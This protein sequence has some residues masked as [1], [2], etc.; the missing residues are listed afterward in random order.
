[1]S[2][3]IGSWLRG[4]A[5]AL[6][7]VAIL[8][9]LIL[10]AVRTG[11]RYELEWIEGS[12]LNEVHRILQGNQLYVAPS[13]EFVP[14]LYPPLYYY[15]SAAV[16]WVIG[17]QMPALRLVSL[18]ATLGTLGLIFSMVRFETRSI[19]AGLV[20]A[21]LYAAMFHLS[22][23]WFDI[24]RVDS[25]F[26]LLLLAA[27]TI[28][29]R[30]NSWVL[31]AAAGL[32]MALAFLTKQSA[33]VVAPALVIPLWLRRP[34]WAAVYAV[35]FLVVAGGSILL[36][37]RVSAGWFV[38]YVLKLPRHHRLFLDH[39]VTFWTQDLLLVVPAMI[40]FFAWLAKA[41]S[42]RPSRPWPAF[43]AVVVLA[44]VALS[45]ASRV[46]E[47]SY[48]NDDVPALAALAIAAPIAAHE[49][50]RGTERRLIKALPQGALVLQFLILAY[51][52]LAQVPTAADATAAQAFEDRLARTAGPVWVPNHGYYPT[53]ARKQAFAHQSPVWDVVRGNA[54][55]GQKILRSSIEEA[56]HQQR[57]ALIILDTTPEIAELPNDFDAYY[58]PVE[59]LRYPDDKVFVPVTGLGT[60]PA[61]VY[62]PRDGHGN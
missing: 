8:T 41:R 28:C 55:P 29:R 49:L 6:A 35:T 40:L 42:I 33:L 62:A 16:A 2:A 26:V 43:L 25:L 11:Y 61:V 54:D 1:M 50:S 45:L 9:C 24:G 52:P 37:D 46:H 23:A 38:Y 36:L 5:I 17:P 31:I 48:F 51:N 32:T 10:M 12:S 58:A 19:T 15:A 39:L 59:E 47:G 56:I 13:V 27:V 53:D 4:V 14:S 22:G 21:G 3:R 60:R 34:R 30:A 44:F 7:C 20:G 18:A 57:F